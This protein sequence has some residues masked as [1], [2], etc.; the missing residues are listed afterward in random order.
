MDNRKYNIF[1][2]LHTVS[3]IVVSVVLFVIFF[4]G[5]F[6]FFRADFNDWQA[7]R[8]SP[9][10][11]YL[12]VDFDD[13]LASLDSAY[14]LQGR[15]IE[16]SRPHAENQF[17]VNLEPTKDSL[18]PKKARTAHYLYIDPKTF[19]AETYEES[20]KI[21]EFLYRLHFFA[22]IPYP[23]GYYLSGFTALFFLFAI[24]TGVLV[25]WKKIVSNFYVFRPKEKLKTLWTDAHTALGMIGLPFQFVYAVTGAFFM[26]NIFLVAP[27]VFTFYGGDQVKLYD[28]LGYLHQKYEFTGKPIGTQLHFDDLI[29]KAERQFASFRIGS[30][31]IENYGDSSQHILAEGSVPKSSRFNGLGEVVFD[32][33]GNVVHKKDPYVSAGYLEMT[34]DLLYRIHYGDYAGYAIKSI[35]FLFGIITCFVILSGV[36]LWLVARDKKNLDE[37]KRKFN[38]RVV[39]I[40]LAISLSMFPVIAA[41]FIAVKLYPDAGMEFLYSF[42][43][44]GWLLLS[45]FFI[46]RKN[47]EFTTFYSLILGS[48]IGLCIPLANGLV[49]GNWFWKVLFS[50]FHPAFVD[51]FWIG[52]SVIA[53]TAGLKMTKKLPNQGTSSKF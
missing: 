48:L 36:M 26:L 4:A 27:S 11:K 8:Y 39:H 5:S 2:H 9:A 12:H 19:K 22:Q 43:F 18:A 46:W 50:E 13:T 28:E 37:K 45:L 6:S 3:G 52:I 38:N 31:H 15:S 14:S 47:N 24:I 30:I 25:H 32:A 51:V 41:T 33:G 1:F 7:N 17:V 29:Q 44:V 40:Y 42:Y 16:I 10:D 23:Y 21:G 20:Y 53:L 35:S 49:T 34:K